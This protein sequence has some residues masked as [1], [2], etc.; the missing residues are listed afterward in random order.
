M[1]ASLM[2]QGVVVGVFEY[3]KD[4]QDA[5]RDLKAA[6]FG[7]THMGLAAPSKN[8]TAVY[9]DSSAKTAAA[10]AVLGLGTG[11][12]WGL[13]VVSGILPGI[14]PAIAAGT[15]AAI[16]S[17]AGVGAAAAG[18]TGALI[19]LGISDEDAEYYENQF[20]AGRIVVTVQAGDRAD[21]AREI[22][23]RFRTATK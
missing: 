21:T 9:T 5:I 17:S 2:T 6:G 11:A 7:E 3:E 10:G 15:L 1:G 14:G 19:G 18:L 20:K 13:G 23:D 12:L 16:L 4:A 8:E 22:M